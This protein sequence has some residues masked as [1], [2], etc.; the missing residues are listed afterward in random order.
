MKKVQMAA[1]A[2]VFS[3][4]AACSGDKDEINSNPIIDNCSLPTGSLKWAI[5]GVSRCADQTLFGDYGILM[6]INGIAG[7]G[8]SLTLQL[9]SVRPGTYSIKADV[10]SI[11]YT[12]NLAMAWQ[13][14]DDNPGTLTIS[15]NDTNTNRFEAT[16]SAT[17]RNPLGASKTLNGGNIKVYYTE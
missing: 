7:N 5:S 14:T 4:L 3:V 13:S 2:I 12:D 16:F 6:T 1:L 17:L 15:L 10:N 8:E 11:L 9:D